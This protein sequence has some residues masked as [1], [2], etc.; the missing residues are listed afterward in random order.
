[1]REGRLAAATRGGLR[2]TP[3]ESGFSQT[4]FLRLLGCFVPLAC[5]APLREVAFFSAT[6]APRNFFSVAR[7]APL[8]TVHYS[9]TRNRKMPGRPRKKA[10]GEEIPR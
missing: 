5:S 4:L 9:Q 7:L 10:G 1:V 8:T 6:L 2:Q 3:L